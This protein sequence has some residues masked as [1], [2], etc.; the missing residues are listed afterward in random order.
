LAFDAA[1]V[2]ALDPFAVVVVAFDFEVD[3]VF[4]VAVRRVVAFEPFVFFVFDAARVVAWDPFAVALDPFGVGVLA[5]F[6]AFD[7]LAVAAFAGR[8][9]FDAFASFGGSVAA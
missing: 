1:R 2:V 6:F 8:F 4:G 9:V 5:R 3:A 7:A